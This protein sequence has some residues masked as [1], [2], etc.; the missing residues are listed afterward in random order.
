[1]KYEEVYLRDYAD[2]REAHQRLAAYFRFCNEDRPHQALDYRTPAEVY[3]GL[4]ARG[5]APTRAWLLELQ[6]PYGLLPF[7][8]PPDPESVLFRAL[9]GPNNGEHPILRLHV[10]FYVRQVRRVLFVK[11]RHLR[12]NPLPKLLSKTEAMLL[13][14][15][16]GDH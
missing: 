12:S 14:Q 9:F 5:T 6:S 11:Q 1:V 13:E 15:A 7:Q 8:Q 4:E 16:R 10:N 3:G 2:P